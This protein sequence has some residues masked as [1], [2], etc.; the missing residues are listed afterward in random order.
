MGLRRGNEDVIVIEAVLEILHIFGFL[1]APGAHGVLDAVTERG[2]AEGW[3]CFVAARDH[4]SSSLAENA[5]SRRVRTRV[6]GCCPYTASITGFSLI[7]ALAWPL[8][9]RAAP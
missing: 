7:W 1:L 5:G 8:Q 3:V 2:A 4:R 9:W 6:R